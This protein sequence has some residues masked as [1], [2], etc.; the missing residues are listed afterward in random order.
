MPVDFLDEGHADAYGR[1]V[2]EP[3]AV[4]PDAV[5]YVAQQVRP[6]QNR[7]AWLPPPSL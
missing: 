6:S 5:A 7:S 2:D 3:T 1:Y 4:P